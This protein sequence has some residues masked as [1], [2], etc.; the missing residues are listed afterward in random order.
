LILLGKVEDQN[1]ILANIGQLMLESM[2]VL[3]AI[4]MMSLAALAFLNGGQS[5]TS[6]GQQHAISMLP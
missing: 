3:F 5:K 2:R 4:K 6:N 1:F